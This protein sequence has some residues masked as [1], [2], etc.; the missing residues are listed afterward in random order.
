MNRLSIF[1]TILTFHNRLVL[2]IQNI[3]RCL[4]N[5]YLELV[6]KFL[7]ETKILK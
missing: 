4:R 6:K 1:I 2:F 5:T 3:K 7:K